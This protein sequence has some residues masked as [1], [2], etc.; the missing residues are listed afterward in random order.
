MST[1]FDSFVVVLKRSGLLSPERLQQVV[2]EFSASH[3]NAEGQQFAADL[4]RT[5]DLTDW[6]VDKL[7][8]GRHKGFFLGK[9]K[10]LKIIGKGGMSSVYLAEHVLMK[11]RC[12]IKVLPWKMV[13]D[14]S[15]LQRFY[16][17]AQLVAQLDHPH[18]VR[19]YDVDHEKEGNIDIHFL[20]MEYVSGRNL[21]EVVSVDGPLSCRLAMDYLRQGCEGLAYAHRVGMVHRDI[22]PGN[23]IVTDEGVVKLMDL[24]LARLSETAE[25]N[26]LTVAH[27]EKVLGTADYLA[28]EQAVDSHSVDARADLYSLGCTLYFMLTG[29]PPF[30]EGTLTQR[31]LAHQTKQP[32]A[33][34]SKRSDVPASLAQILRKL[35]EKD[36]DQ[37]YQ[38]A[39]DVLDD[40][41]GWL[42]QDHNT[43]Q[44]VTVVEKPLPAPVATESPPKL[45]KSSAASKP[46]RKDSSPQIK[47]QPASDSLAG[48]ALDIPSDLIGLHETSDL[49][50]PGQPTSVTRKSGITTK[51]PAVEKTGGNQRI[52]LL[53]GLVAIVII[54]AVGFFLFRPAGE[55]VVENPDPQPHNPPAFVRPAVTGTTVTVGP[56][57]N[58]GTLAEALEYTRSSWFSGGEGAIQEIQIA[59]GITLTEPLVIDNS[60]L[61]VSRP[62][63][64]VG[65]GANAPLLKPE[66]T[67]PVL[68]L[69]ASEQFVLE[70]IRIDGQSRPL[71]AELGGYM[72]GTQLS[73]LT[74]LN[75]TGIAVEGKGVKGLAGRRVKLQDC[76]FELTDAAARAVQLKSEPFKDNA[77]I[78]VARC[79]F[80]GPA[81][82]GVEISGAMNTLTIQECLFHKLDTAVSLSGSDA[83]QTSIQFS[84]NTFHQCSEGVVFSSGLSNYQEKITFV[85]NLFVQQKNAE[86]LV[87]SGSGDVAQLSN[88]MLP[89]KYNWTERSGGGTDELDIFAQDGRRDVP[90]MTFVSEDPANPD[91]LKPKLQELQSTVTQPVTGLNYIGA[92]PL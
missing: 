55:D 79:R 80:L 21:Y 82:S 64:I 65:Q 27:D 86:V 54:C 78:M 75:V 92:L 4:V 67:D 31:L 26:S 7:L 85:Q 10:L 40:L 3:P 16:R 25:D 8:K 19:A 76:R 89:T 61:A 91:F 1:S 90:T 70:N 30:N 57:G 49:S 5:G 20:V 43:P 45:K 51:K 88:G 18:I 41:N 24:G 2:A 22:K 37:R 74:F 44:P 17:E 36:P 9:Y 71:V 69:R 28:P 48:V 50:T 42:K 23:F 66:G 73:R 29:E 63:R 32:P 52:R 11:R 87:R 68:I 81:R 84:N 56:T 58:F 38:T 35:M 15:F 60:L 47:V 46:L 77:E 34:E 39:N 59:E 83:V 72:V 13:A 53:I 6:Q 33:I 62:L 12:A 14:S